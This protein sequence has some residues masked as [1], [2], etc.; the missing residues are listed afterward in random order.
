MHLDIRFVL[1][2]GIA[3]AVIY[4]VSAAHEIGS[5]HCGNHSLIVDSSQ[6]RPI[7]AN[8]VKGIQ[9]AR[10]TIDGGYIPNTIT[11]LAGRPVELE[12][13]RREKSGCASTLVIRDLSIR[14]DVASGSAVTIKFT[15]EEPG[16]IPFECGMGMI[17]GRVI[18][19]KA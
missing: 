12:F 4:A 13:Y 7:A 3:S 15:P 9:K 1:L 16:E 14:K 10:I 6:G 19:K 5:A 17:R 8:E 2:A 11:V 18:I